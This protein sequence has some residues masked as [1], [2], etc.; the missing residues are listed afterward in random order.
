VTRIATRITDPRH[1]MH[2]LALLFFVAGTPAVYAGDEQGFRGLKEDR[3][4]GDD[5]IRPQFP[6]TP[7][8]LAP[9]GWPLYRAHQRLIAL[10][11]DH[12]WLAHA[13]T[14]ALH[15]ANEQLVLAADSADGDHHLA[16]ALNLGDNPFTP[17]EPL[18]EVLLSSTTAS[19]SASASGE[20]PPH[21]WSIHRR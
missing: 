21:A 8:G 7:A 11:R 2:V 20:I 5:A 1:V 12:P 6:P 4:G 13:R 16:L 10:R 15:V 14:T 18:G 19:A 17:P 3:P 9:D